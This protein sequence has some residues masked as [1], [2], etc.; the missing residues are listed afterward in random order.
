MVRDLAGS[1]RCIKVNQQSDPIL[2]AFYT[3]LAHRPLTDVLERGGLPVPADVVAR[4]DDRD[5]PR[6]A[7]LLEHA[8]K[9]EGKASG[10]NFLEGS[11]GQDWWDQSPEYVSLAWSHRRRCGV[12]SPERRLREPADRE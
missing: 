9:F 4:H 7:S 2:F 6:Q 5:Q 1:N 12:C 11:R 10:C 8:A 3:S